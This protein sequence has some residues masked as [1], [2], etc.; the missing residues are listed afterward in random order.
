MATSKTGPVLFEVP[1]DTGDKETCGKI[2]CTQPAS[3]VYLL[4]FSSG[5]DN[6]L[7]SAFCTSLV[8][9][10]DIIEHR[11]PPG[12]VITTSA[13]PKFYSNGM[14][15]EHAATTPGY[16]ETTLY[17]MW[18]RVLTFPMP[19]VALIPGHAFAGG[20]IL[21]LMHD[22]RIMNPAKGWLC[23]NEIQLGGALRGQMMSVFRTK[24]LDAVV[25]RKIILE[26]HR[27]TA[28]EALQE[29]L[30]DRLGGF[31]EA[32]GLVEEVGLVKNAQKGAT[33]LSVYAELKRELWRDVV[34]DLGDWRRDGVGSGA[35]GREI[36]REREEGKR[37]V[38]VW[39]RG[40][41]K[42]RL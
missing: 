8:L 25:Q 20:F 7:R 40:S 12:V 14:D 34:E 32:M 21:A 15:I 3:K 28:Q 29:R 27:F 13:S 33:G 17:P 31:E 16:F 24:V 1:I 38:E 22:Y 42:A 10:L 19:T 4:T 11:H 41:G 36:E 35:M 5:Q 18:R 26:A 9:A 39:E 2:V 37:R 6:R 30:V 23:M